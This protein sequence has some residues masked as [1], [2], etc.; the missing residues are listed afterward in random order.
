MWALAFGS[1]VAL[2]VSG[3][4]LSWRL[5]TN[6]TGLCL[7]IAGFALAGSIYGSYTPVAASP[8]AELL[9]PTVAIA[10]IVVAV[11]RWPTGRMQKRW[12][13]PFRLAVLAFLV[14]RSREQVRLRRVAPTRTLHGWRRASWDLP[15]WADADTSAVGQERRR[16]C[17]SS[18][19][20]RS[21]SSRSSF[22][23]VRACRRACGRPRGPR[24]SLPRSSASPSSGRSRRPWRTSGVSADGPRGSGW[25]VRAS[26]SGATAP[27]HSCSSGRSRCA[28]GAGPSNPSSAAS[29]ELGP[30]EVAVDAS[31]EVGR[32]LGDP[33]ARVVIRGADTLRLVGGDDDARV[34]SD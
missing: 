12:S 17:C 7:T 8:W 24:S 20:L 25:W 26:R 1:C 29:V 3:A 28:D 18:V 22:A 11:S 33:T 32:I 15:T 14:D 34:A 9:L 21:C 4:W 31:E 5:P 10:A 27:S 2:V 6:R 19:S 13:S 30:L 16:R 23:A